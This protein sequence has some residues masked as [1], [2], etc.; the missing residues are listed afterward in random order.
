MKRDSDKAPEHPTSYNFRWE[1]ILEVARALQRALKS[2]D[3]ALNQNSFFFYFFDIINVSREK[4]SKP[5]EYISYLSIYIYLFV[6]DCK[7]VP[8]CW[9][10]KL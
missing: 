5:L 4:V 3:P 2:E 9:I 8:L 10:F 7:T 6:N 1:G